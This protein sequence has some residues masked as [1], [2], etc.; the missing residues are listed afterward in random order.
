M[1]MAVR[2]FHIYLGPQSQVSSS[3]LEKTIKMVMNHALK[4]TKQD[5]WETH[6]ALLWQHAAFELLSSILQAYSS[7]IKQN[8][9]L[10]IDNLL[11]P[12]DIFT[13]GKSLIHGLMDFNF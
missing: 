4:V 3:G 12:D 7:G 10:G 9:R 2:V 6:A 8:V 5:K 13:I 11:V 1:G